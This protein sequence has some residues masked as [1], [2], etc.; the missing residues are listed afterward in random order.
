MWKRTCEVEM[1]H[2]PN[3]FDFVPFA[4]S[5]LLYTPAALDGL[6]EMMSGY[7]EVRLKALTPLHVVGALRTQGTNQSLMYRQ[8]GDVCIP[9]STIRGCLRAFIETLTNGWASQATPEYPKQSGKRHIGY[10]TFEPYKNEFAGKPGQAPKPFWSQPALDAAYRP[11]PQANGSLDIAAYLFGIVTESANRAKP[12]DEDVLTRKGKIFVEDALLGAADLAGNQYWLPDI[13]SRAFMGGGNPSLSSWWYFQPA[14]IRK[15][16]PNVAEFVGGRYWG[17]KFYY[18]QDPVRCTQYYDKQKGHWHYDPKGEFQRVFLECVEAGQTSQHFRIYIDRLPQPLV[19]L[20][21]M[22]LMPGAN[23]RH[24]LGY[25]KAYGYGSVEFEIVAAKLRREGQASRI[26][27]DLV[28]GT[29]EVLAWLTA[30]WGREEL[31]AAKL[32]PLLDFAALAHLAQVC[33]WVD[34]ETLLFT[35]PPFIDS[36]RDKSA[37]FQN[38][39]R[40]SVLQDNLPAG[41]PH[42]DQITV[43]EAE[44]RAI[45]AALFD[46]VKKPIHFRYYQERAA[47]WAIITRRRP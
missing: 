45:A 46:R 18:H 35:Y 24:K 16:A 25:G 22:V 21:V 6:G 20:L 5:P 1:M 26:P 29:G 23:I 11:T 19:R 4:E 8:D 34:S 17:R 38:A 27:G 37:Q 14:Q 44:A 13:N 2:N 40:Y 41:I 10:K 12:S 47:G 32:E 36:R 28:D 31:K 15:R 42:S 33:G 39:I 30:G 43:S 7:L 3:P 9:G